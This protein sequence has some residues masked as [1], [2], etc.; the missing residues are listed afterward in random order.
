MPSKQYINSAFRISEEQIVLAGYRIGEMLNAI[1]GS[2]QTTAFADAENNIPCKII[3]K[4]PYPVTK[5]N[6]GNSKM[7]IAL[8]NLCPPNRGMAARPMTS[9]LING[10]PKMFEY[11]VEKVFKTE[12]EARE[13][14]EK[15]GIK[16]GSF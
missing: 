6:T 16:D 3:R 11:D 14:A 5:T 8:L 2:G 15:N 1:F 10:Q 7:E 4:V 9:F 12:R 13:Y